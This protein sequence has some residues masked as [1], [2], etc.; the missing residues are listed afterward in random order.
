[1]LFNLIRVGIIKK[2][3]PLKNMILFV[4]NKRLRNTVYHIYNPRDC[5]KK[6]QTEYA[7]L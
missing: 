5:V 7:M 6:K 3:F 4:V 1:M 2:N